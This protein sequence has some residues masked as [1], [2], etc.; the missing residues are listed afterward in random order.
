[1]RRTFDNIFAWPSDRYLCLPCGPVCLL[2]Y[3]AVCLHRL[4][5]LRDPSWSVEAVRDSIDL[6]ATI[7]RVI[8]ICQDCQRQ[9]TSKMESASSASSASNV[10]TIFAIRKFQALRAVWLNEMPPRNGTSS[11][12]TTA[13]KV[14]CAPPLSLFPSAPLPLPPVDDPDYYQ[15]LPDLAMDLSWM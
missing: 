11:A 1:M 4:T 9:M 12:A 13:T 6:I 5:T 8:A 14:P 2:I 15:W 7:D 3:V 10:V